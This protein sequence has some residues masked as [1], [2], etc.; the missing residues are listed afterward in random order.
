MTVGKYVS[1]DHIGK[2]PWP[3]RKKLLTSPFNDNVHRSARFTEPSFNRSGNTT[4][5]L[6]MSV[7]T[8][9]ISTTP[10]APY[11]DDAVINESIDGKYVFAAT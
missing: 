6:P 8:V 3:L 10:C 9:S 1:F 2:P 11:S 7:S 4:N 5:P